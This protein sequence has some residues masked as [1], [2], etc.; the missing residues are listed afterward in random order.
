MSA[1]FADPQPR[2]LGTQEGGLSLSISRL[3]LSDKKNEKNGS[4]NAIKI[5]GM[6]QK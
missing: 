2:H 3:L 6:R 1:A 5:D 4:E